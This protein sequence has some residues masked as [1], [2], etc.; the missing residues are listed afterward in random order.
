MLSLSS[1]TNSVN[2][3]SIA[4]LNILC[5][6][7]S[8]LRVVH[9][10]ARS[11]NNLKMDYVRYVFQSSG[12]DVICISETW[13]VSDVCDAY[14]NINSYKLVRNDRVGKKAVALLF[15]A[16]T[17]L[18]CAQSVSRTMGAWSFCSS[19]CLTVLI[20]LLSRVYITQTNMYPLIRFC[21]PFFF[22]SRLRKYYYMW[23]FQC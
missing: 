2:D 20:R 7:Q 9:F 14:Y 21:I 8:G 15:I 5:S 18:A 6:Q 10:N 22:R 12:V 11:L 17:T 3:N 13:F 19:N 4:M 16:R 1:K 23:R